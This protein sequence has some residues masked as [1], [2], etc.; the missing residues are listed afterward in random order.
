MDVADKIAEV[1]T[2]AENP[3]EAVTI[4]GVVVKQ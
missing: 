3:I 1:P 2:Q 4:T